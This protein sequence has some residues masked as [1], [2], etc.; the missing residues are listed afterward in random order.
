MESILTVTISLCH[1]SKVS[2][3][4]G[5]GQIRL[6]NHCEELA[7]PRSSSLT[8]YYLDTLRITSPYREVI[9][10]VSAQHAWAGLLLR[11]PHGL[12]VLWQ[13]AGCGQGHPLRRRKLRHRVEPHPRKGWPLGGA[14]LA[15]YPRRAAAVRGNYRSTIF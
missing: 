14:V 15:E 5:K 2:K 3:R 9:P 8:T 1:L 13:S 4:S 7:Q 10:L 6:R 11:N 12:E